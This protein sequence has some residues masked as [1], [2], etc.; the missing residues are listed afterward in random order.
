MKIHHLLLLQFILAIAA[1]GE[2]LTTQFIGGNNNEGIMFDLVA[3][4]PLSVTAIQFASVATTAGS[5]EIYAKLGT[6]VG[7]EGTAAQWSLLTTAPFEAGPAGAAKAPIPLPVPISIPPGERLALYIRQVSGL[8]AYSNG[9]GIFAADDGAL[10]ILEGTGVA[11]TFGVATPNRIPNVTIHYSLA[12]DVLTTT[13]KGT[14]NNRGIVFD[15]FAKNALNIHSIR[16]PGF[17]A[18]NHSVSVYTR[19]GSHV[20]SEF[21]PAAWTLLGVRFSA[22]SVTRATFSFDLEEPLPV[23]LGGTRA[24]FLTSGEPGL[25]YYSNGGPELTGNVEAEDANLRILKGQGMS[26]L[27]FG[28][29]PNRV[30]NVSILYRDVDRLAPTISIAGPRRI[31]AS[32]GSAKIY[33]V[34]GDDLALDRVE[35]RF[36]RVRGGKPGPFVTQ[37]IP[38]Q[39]SG[40]FL[41]NLKLA[42]GR[43]T[44]TFRARDRSGRSSTPV[45][46]TVIQ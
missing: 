30:P 39:P 6:H 24:F 23:P 14:N 3:D 9:T 27:F 22:T 1:S 7:S 36:R 44:A 16:F 46:V 42:P 21:D 25:V 13:F 43:N 17:A 8:L 12:P 15:V 11:A 18:G 45:V 37:R 19:L 4:K 41:L 33:G 20:G 32:G 5:L 38:V 31:R 35:A 40:L 2:T 10:R 29:I 34:A 28:A 26:G